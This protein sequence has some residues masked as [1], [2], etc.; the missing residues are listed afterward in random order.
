MVTP[1]T[2]NPAETKESLIALQ[3]QAMKSRNHIPMKKHSDSIIVCTYGG[4]SI[5]GKNLCMIYENGKKVQCVKGYDL[6]F[7]LDTVFS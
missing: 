6:D 2:N 1:I 4:E 3:N 7:V 5:T